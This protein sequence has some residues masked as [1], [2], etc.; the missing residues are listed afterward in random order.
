[1]SASRTK[2]TDEIDLRVTHMD[3]KK[4]PYSDDSDNDDDEEEEK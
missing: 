4:N 2:L 3:W 1:M